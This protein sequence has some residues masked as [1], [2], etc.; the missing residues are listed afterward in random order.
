MT[1]RQSLLIASVLT[2]VA[3]IVVPV[4]A[5]APITVKMATLV[6][7]NSSSFLVLAMTINIWIWR[8]WRRL[9]RLQSLP[10]FKKIV[11]ASNAKQSV[12]RVY[13]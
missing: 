1:R 8:V 13:R 10:P 6:P 4:Q 5:Q 7:E 9:R 3:G 12:C 2:L 11:I